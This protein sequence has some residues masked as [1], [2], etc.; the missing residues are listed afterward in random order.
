MAAVV[1]RS[2]V[3]P[4]LSYPKYRDALRYDFWFACAYCGITEVEATSISFEIDHYHPVARDGTDDYS[5]LMWCCHACNS[6]KGDKWPSAKHQ[7]NGYRYV[8]PDVDDPSDHYKLRDNGS[9]RIETLTNAGEW[10]DAILDLNRAPLRKLREVR[11]HLFESSEAISFGLARLSA[12][13]RGLDKVKPH[14]RGHYLQAVDV[15][16]GQ[17]EVLQDALESIEFDDFIRARN[18]SSNIEQPEERRAHTQRRREFL[19]NLNALYPD[20]TD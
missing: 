13:K 10:T 4:G 5:N 12:S 16:I 19:K 8:R 14:M 9:V 2:E 17:A 20:Y 15:A 7:E 3:Q 1:A 6:R 11:R 18:K